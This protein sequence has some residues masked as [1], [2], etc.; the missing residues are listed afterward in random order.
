MM[1]IGGKNMRVKLTLIYPDSCLRIIQESTEAFVLPNP[2]LID[3]IF[4]RAIFCDEDAEDTDEDDDTEREERNDKLIEIAIEPADLPNL[5]TIGSYDIIRV[6]NLFDVIANSPELLWLTCAWPNVDDWTIF[7]YLPKLV[8]IENLI[9]GSGDGYVRFLDARQLPALER[10]ENTMPNCE[11]DDGCSTPTEISPFKYARMNN[12]MSNVWADVLH[13][14]SGIYWQNRCFASV[15][16]WLAN[17]SATT[18]WEFLG[19]T[20][21]R[22]SRAKS[23]YK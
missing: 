8:V 20:D 14:D 18:I 4:M 22:P 11:N 15:E 9:T 1:A 6:T 2:H 12:A 5:V 19:T 23:A 17:T 16:E 7:P 10:I 13:I 3:G 21:P